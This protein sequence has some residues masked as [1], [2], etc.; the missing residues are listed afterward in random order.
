MSYVK[1]FILLF[2]LA[3]LAFA[4]DFWIE[5]STFHPA[6]G[7]TVLVSLRVGQSFAGDPVPRSA[8]LIDSFTVN[9]KPI[10]GFENH[11][12][13]GFFRADNGSVSMIGYRSKPSPLE[14][15][16]AKFEQFLRDEGLEAIR[17]QRARRGESNKP[18]RERFYR[19]AKSLIGSGA[20]KPFG[21][22]LEIVPDTD[23][24][25]VQVV[26]EGKP[27]AGALV[28]AL[29]RDDPSLKL[30]LRTDAHGRAAFALPR[31]GV[32]L[33]KS[34]QL[35]P[36]PPKSDYDWESLWASLTFER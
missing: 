16:A 9:D 7:Q 3:P 15:D 24:S 10:L 1:R 31:K 20:T 5:P 33:I 18:D 8:Q 13:A 14:L 22:R 23:P 19:Y 29:Y 12:P 36:A 35:V 32:W 30:Q 2:T 25:R 27:L 11:D 28:T 6:P 17:A 34:V 4:H 21:W 26:F